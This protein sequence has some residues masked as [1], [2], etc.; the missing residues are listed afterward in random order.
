MAEEKVVEQEYSKYRGSLLQLTN[1]K[2]LNEEERVNVLVDNLILVDG[3][4][5]KYNIGGN[6]NFV[7]VVKTTNDDDYKVLEVEGITKI[8]KDEDEN[9]ILLLNLDAVLGMS[10]DWH[11]NIVADPAIKHIGYKYIIHAAMDDIE[12]YIVFLKG[13]LYKSFVEYMHNY[14][15]ENVK[16]AEQICGLTDELNKKVEE[17]NG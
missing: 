11:E 7:L 9:E 15:L 8:T 1:P 2:D 5:R 10:Y 13:I 12:L 16:T 14:V 3:N 4:Y 6:A 17:L